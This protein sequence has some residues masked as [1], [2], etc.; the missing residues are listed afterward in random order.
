[1]SLSTKGQLSIEYFVAM[2]IFIF[3]VVYFL[4]QMSNLVPE[5][6]GEMESQRIRSEA[7][8]ISEIMINGPG[9]PANWNTLPYSQTVLFGLSNEMLNKTNLLSSSKISSMNSTCTSLGQQ[10]I[11]SKIYTD[12]EMSMLIV[13][14][15]DGTPRLD[16]NAPKNNTR[17]FSVTVRRIVAFDDGKFGDLTLQMWRP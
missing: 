5:F 16:C 14:R 1:M 13:D 3:F 17:G 4:F 2:I 6:T 15:T 9:M 12:L 11:K 7:Y 8:Q 10:A